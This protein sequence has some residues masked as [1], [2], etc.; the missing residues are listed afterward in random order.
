MTSMGGLGGH[1]AHLD[2]A[3]TVPP[4][5]LLA[6]SI[7]HRIGGCKVG[8]SQQPI[9]SPGLQSGDKKL[10]IKGEAAS[11]TKRSHI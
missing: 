7:A 1:N 11:V 5:A 8:M 10:K 9:G 2:V 4:V 3:H 6:V